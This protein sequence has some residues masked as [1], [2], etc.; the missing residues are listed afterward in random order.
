[1]ICLL[2]NFFKRPKYLLYVFLSM[3]FHLLSEDR[4][5]ARRS[6][7]EWVASPSVIHRRATSIP[8][9]SGREQPPLNTQLSTHVRRDTA[10]E[11]INVSGHEHSSNSKPVLAAGAKNKEL[12]RVAGQSV[13]TKRQRSPYVKWSKEEDEML[14]QAVAKYGQKWD[15]VQKALPSRGYHQVRQRWL[16]KLGVFDSKPDLSSFQTSSFSS[17][18]RPPNGELGSPTP[19]EPPPN[20]KLGLAPLSSE[21]AFVTFNSRG[22]SIREAS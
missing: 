1:M 17:G 16:R 12:A 2:P 20:P 6:P 19:S 7:V 14:A 18:T 10:P 4:T 21:L 3:H 22:P 11:S 9:S 13:P 8:A 15:L 5:N